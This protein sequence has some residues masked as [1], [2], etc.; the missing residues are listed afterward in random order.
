MKS[1]GELKEIDMKNCTCYD[2]NNISKVGDFDFDNILIDEKNILKIM[3]RKYKNILVYDK[4][5]IV[6]KPL[7]IRLITVD[8][9]IRAYN[10]TRYLV[11]FDPENYVCICNR[12]R[13]LIG[14]ESA[15]SYVISHDYARIKIDSCDSLALD[16][17]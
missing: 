10:G 5:N 16:F 7:R 14:Q 17:A 11:L 13:Y 9:F 3:Y 6:A 12:I 4:Q 2:F 1:N 8:G 15:I